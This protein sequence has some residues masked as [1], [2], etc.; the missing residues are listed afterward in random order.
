M[1]EQGL[2]KV[3]ARGGAWLAASPGS[4]PRPWHGIYR[5]DQGGA[6]LCCFR[7]GTGHA[8]ATHGAPGGCWRGLLNSDR[9]PSQ[10][11]AKMQKV[12]RR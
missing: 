9:H 12:L 10:P 11:L 1:D 5:V 4:F 2:E 3:L 8:D 6:N 7:S